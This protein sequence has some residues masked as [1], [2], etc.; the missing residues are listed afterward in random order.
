LDDRK[1]IKSDTKSQTA[2]VVRT[3]KNHNLVI[4]DRQK[5]TLT[6]VINVE[7]FNELEIVLETELG[8]LTI[9]GTSLHMSRLNLE[10]GE[11]MIDG[12]IDS[13][14]YSEKHDMKTK[15]ASFF[16]KLFK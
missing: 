13:C 6:G 14:I 1:N 11:L 4:E 5:M 3:D 10:S 2:R 9:K 15:G 16:S 7:N 12:S 8:I